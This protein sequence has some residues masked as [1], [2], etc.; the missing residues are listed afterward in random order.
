MKKSTRHST[1]TRTRTDAGVMDAIRGD[2]IKFIGFERVFIQA[3][4]CILYKQI[5]NMNMNKDK[6]EQ[7]FQEIRRASLWR[8][9]R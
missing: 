6:I 2:A 3:K 8:E 4:R 1:S 7:K 5:K 9:R